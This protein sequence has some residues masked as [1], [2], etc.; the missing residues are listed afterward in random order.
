MERG[1]VDARQEAIRAVFE[2]AFRP[3]RTVA[4]IWGTKLRVRVFGADDEPL[5]SFA[6]LI[7]AEFH[8]GASLAPI[9]NDA[10]E[11]LKA[12]PVD[13]GRAVAARSTSSLSDC[14]SCWPRGFCSSSSFEH[15]AASATVTGGVTHSSDS[16]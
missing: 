6:E 12:F 3:L 4:E 9:V 13:T 1:R 10:R 14:Q 15:Y 5:L 2:G 8:S 11:R 16:K 7:L